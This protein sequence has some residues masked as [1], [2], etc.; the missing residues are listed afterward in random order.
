MY[1]IRS[2]YAPNAYRR[3]RPETYVPLHPS[4]G[5][6]NRGV[7]L[8]VPVS[9]PENRRVEHRVA[10][11]DVN[12]YLLAAVVLAGIHHGLTGKLDPGPPVRGNAYAREDVGLPTNWPSAVAA[13]ERS[14]FRNN[15]V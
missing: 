14:D 6:N 7:A 1:A 8:R 4:W 2:Y 5:I 10:G 13:F 11:A 15:F 3:F 12:P 9:S